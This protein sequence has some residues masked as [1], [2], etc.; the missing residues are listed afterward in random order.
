MS[1]TMTV[2]EAL[3]ERHRA[4]MV[5][6][7]REIGGGLLRQPMLAASA[8]VVAVAVAAALAPGAF[9]GSD[10]LQVRPAAKLHPPDSAHLFGTD[11]LGRDLFARVVHGAGLSLSCAVIAVLVGLVGGS[12]VGLVAGFAGGPLDAAIMRAVD[13]LLAVPSLLLATTLVTAFGFG[14]AQT[15]FAVGTSSIAAFARLVRA[16][17]MRV[18]EQAYV[19]AALAAGAR[20]LTV[21]RRHV[22][23]HTGGAVFA[24]AALEFGGAILAVSALGFLGFGAQPPS[25]EWGALIADGR[26]YLD[27]AWWM[28]AAP[29]LAVVLTVLALNRISQAFESPPVPRR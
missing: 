8:V 24:L 28:T 13:V 5:R 23:P 15:A 18:R 17:V 4:G 19:E 21:L 9:T 26:G 10:P 6:R 20:H 14:P 22:L 29:G 3:G 25:P 11:Q 7:G 1:G 2:G 27:T 12:L 16:E